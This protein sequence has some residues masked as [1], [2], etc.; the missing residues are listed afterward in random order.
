MLLIIIFELNL[1][2]VLELSQGGMASF[3]QFPVV[4]LPTMLTSLGI[5]KLYKVDSYLLILFMSN[6]Y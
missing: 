4:I 1:T 3:V 6:G 5:T 2:L